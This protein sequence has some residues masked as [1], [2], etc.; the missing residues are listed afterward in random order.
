MYPLE[1]IK[2]RLAT[3]RQGEFKSILHC[4]RTVI[5]EGGAMSLF[6]GISPALI[7]ILPY[8]GIDLAMYEYI[9]FVIIKLN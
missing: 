3:S 5:Q 4:A 9:L 7:G 8:A 6:R 2:T 1:T